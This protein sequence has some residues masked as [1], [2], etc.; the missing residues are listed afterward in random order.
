MNPAGRLRCR[1]T[2]NAM[3]TGL[4]FK[5]GPRPLS[6]NLHHPFANTANAGFTDRIDFALPA[7][8]FG[9]SQV[10]A[11]EFAGKDARLVA[12]SARSHFNQQ[13]SS[14]VGIRLKQE[15]RES[16][17][18]VALNRFRLGTIRGGEFAHLR[19]GTRVSLKST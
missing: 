9:V 7:L 11:E 19:I 12:T 14:V 18:N 17:E 10:G 2:L 1:D 15:A 16:L 3:H 8:S 6:R 13:V 4:P 5:C